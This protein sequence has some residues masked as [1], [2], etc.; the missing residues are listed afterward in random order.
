MDVYT[1]RAAAATDG[2]TPASTSEPSIWD[3]RVTDRYEHAGKGVHSAYNRAHHQPKVMR[4]SPIGGCVGVAVARP[5]RVSLQPSLLRPIV[6][7]AML[8]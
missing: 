3:R 1:E 5:L 2:S 6:S 4:Y 7:V 8:T